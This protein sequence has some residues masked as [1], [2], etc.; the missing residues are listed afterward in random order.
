M[1]L[2]DRG[3]EAAGEAFGVAPLDVYV[4]A[5]LGS[6]AWEC[7]EERGSSTSTTTCRSWRS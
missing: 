2:S 7:P 4:T 1:P 3:R 5:E 6:V